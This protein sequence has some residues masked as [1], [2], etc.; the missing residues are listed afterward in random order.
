MSFVD[1]GEDFSCERDTQGGSK[2]VGEDVSK[3]VS[4]NVIY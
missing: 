4:E 1:Y 3:L 2:E